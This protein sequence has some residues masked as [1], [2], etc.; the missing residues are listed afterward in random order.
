MKTFTYKAQQFRFEHVENDHTS[1]S[2][3]NGTFYEAKLLEQILSLQL[4]GTY[5]DIGSH[6]GNHSVYFSKIC[7]SQHVV[8]VEG[9]PFN[10]GYLKA[11][12]ALNEC[13][14]NSL[15]QSI[16]HSVAGETLQMKYNPANTGESYVTDEKPIWGKEHK[17]T[18]NTTVT[19]DSILKNYE[20]ITLIKLD[21]DNHGYHALLGAIETIDKWRPIIVIQLHKSN[22]NYTEI[23]ALLE[24]KQYMRLRRQLRKQPD[25]YRPT[26]VI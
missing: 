12:I 16:A 9:N 23:L 15:Y 18:S 5:V 17:Y 10:F 6:H 13:K 14:N 26:E 7:P 11:N 8:S 24:D 1:K 3:T 21:I 22:P 4:G 20:N 25:F 19:L 2:W